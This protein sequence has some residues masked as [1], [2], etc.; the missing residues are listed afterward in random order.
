VN[1]DNLVIAYEA[2]WAIG[3]GQV[4]EPWQANQTIAS[5]RDYLGRDDISFLYG[6]SV[7]PSNIDAIMLQ[8]CIDGVMVGKSS[9]EPEALAQIAN[10]SK[11]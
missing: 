7:K 8:P 11:E 10:F 5:I 1:L 2:I 3:T 4:C 9:L 6:G